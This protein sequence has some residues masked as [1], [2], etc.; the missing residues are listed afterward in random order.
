MQSAEE[1]KKA[2]ESFDSED[3]QEL[4][5]QEKD[6]FENKI[7]MA[8]PMPT[9]LSTVLICSSG[10]AQALTKIIFD[11]KLTQIGKTTTTQKDKTKDTVL[12][13]HVADAGLLVVHP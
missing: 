1:S 10:E 13:Y 11:G 6:K 5:D 7:E 4:I 8:S 2:D 3:E 12:F 9:E